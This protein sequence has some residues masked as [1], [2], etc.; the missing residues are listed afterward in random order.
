MKTPVSLDI[1]V[2]KNYF[3][4]LFMLE[5]GRSKRFEI[6]NGDTSSFDPEA[7]LKI[8]Q[9]EK[10]EIVTFNGNSYDIPILTLSLINQNTALLKSA[11]SKIIERDM[12]PWTFYRQEGLKA[13]DLNHVDLIEVAPSMVG[14]KLYGG[15]LGSKRLQELPIEHTAEITPEQVPIL[16]EYCKNDTAVTFDLYR[17]LKK[18]IDLRRVMGERYGLDLMSKSDAQIAEAVLKS[19]YEKITGGA[20]QKVPAKS[21]VFRYDPPSY[22]RFSTPVLQDVFNTVCQADMV[23]K[24]DTGHVKMPAEIQNLKITIGGSTYKI[25]IGGLHSQESEVAHHSDDETILVDRDVASYYPAMMLNM[26]MEPG[27]FGRHFNPIY[28]SIL[29]ERLEA[30]HAGDKSK[31]DSLKIVLNGTFGKTSSKY[32]TLYSPDFMIRTTLSGQLT[33]LMLIEALE[34]R[35]I[36]VVSANTDGIVIECPRDRLDEVNTLIGKWEKHTGLDTEETVYKSLYSRDVNNYIAVKPDG[37][38]KGKGVFGPVTLS[39]NPQSPICPLAVIEYLTNGVPFDVTI[40]GCTDISMFLSLRTVTG[41]AVK[42]EVPLGKA[43]RWYYSTETSTNITYLKNGNSVPKSKGAKPLMDIPDEFPSDVDY[44]WY[45]RE[46]ESLL[47][48]LGAKE[49]PFVEKI[50]RKNSKAWKNLVELGEIVE[51]DEG[52]WEWVDAR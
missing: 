19:E 7:I 33:L 11:S 13:P 25:G 15:R 1:E 36:P 47:M 18:Q 27:G 48:D 29:D 49:R 43:I 20:P 30:K 46:C 24:K 22:I 3:L 35:S 26:N 40:K 2:Y 42:D 4:A 41:G 37:T 50:P 31:S 28:R 39:K 52:K 38:V 44:G 21:S 8:L 51:N 32:S 10:F 17:A 23:I 45:I 14:L 9:N 5:D 16:R 34:K 6:F 12:K